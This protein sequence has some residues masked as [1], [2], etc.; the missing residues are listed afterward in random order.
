MP[1]ATHQSC[2]VCQQVSDV[3]PE[4]TAHSY[5]K[6]GMERDRERVTGRRAKV[7]PTADP[8]LTTSLKAQQHEQQFLW[9]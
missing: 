8:Y 4:G 5:R 2:P 3:A 1:E 6:G 7:P 9:P